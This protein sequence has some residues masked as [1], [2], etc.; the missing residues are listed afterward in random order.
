[1]NPV[2]AATCQ[3]THNLAPSLF[4][5]VNRNILIMPTCRASSRLEAS[6]QCMN[7]LLTLYRPDVGIFLSMVMG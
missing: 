7:G 3:L 1:M 5:M 2:D 6:A 4:S